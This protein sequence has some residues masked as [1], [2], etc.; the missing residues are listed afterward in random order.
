MN[1]EKS[2][3]SN[4]GIK[5]IRFETEEETKA[6]IRIIK[7]QM[8]RRVEMELM[9][10]STPEMRMRREFR[11]AVGSKAIQKWIDRHCPNFEEIVEQVR[12]DMEEEIT[13]YRSSI[14]G[15]VL[16]GA[17]ERVDLS[18]IQIWEFLTRTV[19]SGYGYF[20]KDKEYK[21]QEDA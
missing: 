8:D 3:N 4:P 15:I 18:E 19:K 17:D 10:I 9:M 7:K 12:N 13:K 1:S 16:D 11:Q 21:K 5:G 14:P 6:F 20:N 2:V